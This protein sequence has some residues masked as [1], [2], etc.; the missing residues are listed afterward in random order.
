VARALNKF[1][2]FL[3]RESDRRVSLRYFPQE[4]FSRLLA[5]SNKVRS[6][7][8]FADHSGQPRS[9]EAHLRRLEKLNPQNVAL[10]GVLGAR[11]YYPDLD[12]VGTP[13]LDISV[14]CGE[15]HANL[16]FIE[17]LDPA[18]KREGDPLKTANVV[19]HIVRDANPLFEPREGGLL[20]ADPVECLLDLHEARLKGLATQ[21]LNAL[22]RN[23]LSSR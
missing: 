16:S 23:R 14:H 15:Q 3:A 22:G 4:E 2:G 7:I 13:L 11:H 10:G 5:N 8:R 21:F 20:W 9:P 18:L 6:T 17:K 12:I 19:V 1:G